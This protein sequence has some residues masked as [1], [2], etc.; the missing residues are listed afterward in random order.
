MTRNA[1][2]DCEDLFNCTHEPET[3]ILGADGEISHW[4]CRCGQKVETPSEPP[5][6]DPAPTGG[7]SREEFEETLFQAT[8][9]SDDPRKRD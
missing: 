4:V 5:P 6:T 3:P 7:V 9:T 8:L 1:D 2:L